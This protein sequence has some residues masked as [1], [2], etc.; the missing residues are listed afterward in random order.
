MHRLTKPLLLF[1]EGSLWV[2]RDRNNQ[3]LIKRIQTDTVPTVYRA[4]TP[5]EIV[6]ASVR[7][8]NPARNVEV[9]L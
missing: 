6:A 2:V 7:R 9:M 8:K 3:E 1:V 4:N 5:F